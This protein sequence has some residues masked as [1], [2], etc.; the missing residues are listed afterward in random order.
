MKRSRWVFPG[1]LLVTLVLLLSCEGC[2]GA[3]A[4]ESDGGG[5][6]AGEGGGAPLAD[7]GRSDGADGGAPVETRALVIEPQGA[8][9]EATVDGSETL[10]LSAVFV[11]DDGNREPAEGAFWGS[12]NPEV[13]SVD[14]DGLFAPSRERAGTAR[15]RARARGVEGVGEVRVV[16]RETVDVGGGGA[17]PGDFDGAVG[18]GPGPS[19]LYPPDGVVIPSNLAPILFQWDKTKPRARVLLDGAHGSL[20]LYTTGDRAEAPA[21][22]WRRFLVAHVGESFTVTVE[23]S[24]GPGSER[25]QSQL[26]VHLADA[27]LTS[28]VYYWAVDQGRIVRIDADSLEPIA[29]DI[30]FDNVPE[31]GVPAGAGEQQCRACHA[32]SADGQHMAFTY[33]GGN[34]P[35]GVVDTSSLAAPTLPNRDARR[36]NFAAISPDGSLLLTNYQRRLHLRS[37]TSGDVILPDVTG[38]DAAHPAFSPLG[39]RVAFAGDILVS[40]APAG[41]E[42]DF[43]QSNLYIADVNPLVP[44]VGAP[45]MVVPGEGEAVYYPSFS[46]DGRLLAYT[47]GPHSRSANNNVHLRG[48]LF[49]AAADAAPG[50]DGVPRVELVRANPGRSSYL[51]TFNPKIEGGYLWIAFYSRRD[52]GHVLRG[53]GS[54][55]IWVAAISADADP[56]TSSED[57]SHPAFWLPGQSSDTDNLSSFFAPKPCAPTGGACE[58]D[59]ACCGELLCRPEGGVYQCVPP[60]GA[61]ALTGD[62]CVDDD[63]CCDGLL[64]GVESAGGARACLPPGQVCSENGQICQLDADCCDD[65]ALCADDGTG[66]LRCLTDEE[67]PCGNLYSSCEGRP[68][69]EGQGQCLGGTCL[70]IEG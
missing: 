40:G 35:G 25:A 2:P 9:L 63:E 21:D 29:L 8:V 59:A 24:D 10:Q 43:N 57:P 12:L 67:L 34:G 3:V 30:P 64:C 46:P 32:L 58:S 33:F 20:A 11:D 54:P 45:V 62:S 49:L 48:D 44:S 7:G 18:V 36:W 52:Y 42:I 51:P 16:L 65:A 19:V 22:A 55:Q 23:E 5:S 69:C 68:C 39:N 66:V 17:G 4:G 41:W 14:G 70:I 27:D 13:G 31:G 53:S 38:F 28:T 26:T 6:V 56:A 1:A 15:V 60:E 50:F 61:C 47:K 37:G